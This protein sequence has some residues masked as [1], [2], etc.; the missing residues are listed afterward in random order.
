MKT[1][2]KVVFVIL[3]P[4]FVRVLQHISTS[5]M[6]I[7]RSLMI[8]ACWEVYM[9]LVRVFST[10]QSR[11]KHENCCIAYFIELHCLKAQ[12]KL[13]CS[14]QITLIQCNHLHNWHT[15]FKITWNHGLLSWYQSIPGPKLLF[16]TYKAGQVWSNWFW[17]SKHIK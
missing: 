14:V 4:L 12:H 6:L 9:G 17:S 1:L 3:I 2:N 16:H 15:L 10:Q 8:N 13:L 7:Y 5:H 11:Q